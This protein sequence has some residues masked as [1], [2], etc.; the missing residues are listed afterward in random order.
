[1]KLNGFIVRKIYLQ[2]FKVVKNF[3][4]KLIIFG[5]IFEKNLEKLTNF[6]LK[7][8]SKTVHFSKFRN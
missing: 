6:Y 1:M 5:E 2:E 4:Q 3:Q 7:K 8:F